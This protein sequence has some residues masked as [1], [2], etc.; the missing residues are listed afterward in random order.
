MQRF[1]EKLRTLRQRNG[2]TLTE[3]AEALGYAPQTTGYISNF[4]TGKRKP[5]LELVI[6]VA[7]FFQVTTDQL[8]RDDLEVE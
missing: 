5:T 6:K 3:L 2:M 7:N 8:V 4:E 1:G